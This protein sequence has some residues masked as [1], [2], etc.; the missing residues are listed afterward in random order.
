MIGPSP[1]GFLSSALAS[2]GAVSSSSQRRSIANAW[3]F[4]ARC[5]G[6]SFGVIM[7]WVV[8]AASCGHTLGARSRAARAVTWCAMRT[9]TK[10]LAGF[11]IGIAHRQLQMGAIGNNI[12]LA[13]T[14]K[15]TDGNHA[16]FSGR[17]FSGY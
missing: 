5:C 11:Q 12:V 10:C 3:P 2:S 16:R 1:Y 8:T 7:T 9:A 15:G 4:W 17:Q 6:V 13:A 14:V